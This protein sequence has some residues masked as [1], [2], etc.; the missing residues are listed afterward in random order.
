MDFPLE[1]KYSQIFPGRKLS[2]FI[3]TPMTLK[4]SWFIKQR[5]LVFI[6]PIE[7]PPLL[8]DHTFTLIAGFMRGI[9]NY[10]YLGSDH[11]LVNFI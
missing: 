10:S 2:T 6:N 3:L 7:A 9:I 8:V 11:F 4:Q 5:V 1:S